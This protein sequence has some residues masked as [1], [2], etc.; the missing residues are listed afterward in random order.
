MKTIRSIL[1]FFFLSG[2][3]L[4]YGHNFHVSVCYI[5]YNASTSSL[6]ISLNYFVDDLEGVLA[7]KN[8]ELDLKLNTEREYKGSDSLLFDYLNK[9]F[10]VS[11][12]GKEKVIEFVGKEY[13]T[14]VVWMYLKIKKV[15]PFK[16]MEIYHAALV[17]AFNDQS[18]LVHITVG[19]F[20]K[21]LILT[22]S[23]PKERLMIN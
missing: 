15:N 10:K 22:K 13:E 6:E 18:N 23:Q 8:P 17:D 21:S 1:L 11:L 14:D 12:D 16:S 2:P 5:D 9:K 4:I 3:T 7:K 19:E 20:K